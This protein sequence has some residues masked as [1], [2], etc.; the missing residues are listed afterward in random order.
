MHLYLSASTIIRN[1]T[2]YLTK[3]FRTYFRKYFKTYFRKYFR[4]Y[5][6]K[7]EIIDKVVTGGD[8]RS[9]LMAK[10]KHPI[11]DWVDE[12][13]DKCYSGKLQILIKQ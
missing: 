5:L 8:R 13:D 4:T 11:G 2:K 10:E 1:F 7:Y 12:Q 9:I 6:T 3:Y